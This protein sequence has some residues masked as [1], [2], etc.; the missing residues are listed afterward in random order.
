MVGMKRKGRRT[1]KEIGGSGKRKEGKKERRQR[2][3]EGAKEIKK[4][5]GKK[6]TAVTRIRTW[7]ITATT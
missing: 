5:G 3:K 7:V 6:K 2:K 1:L 4:S